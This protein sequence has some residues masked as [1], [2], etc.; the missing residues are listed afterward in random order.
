MIMTMKKVLASLFALF[1][2]SG[3][4]SHAVPAYPGTIQ[5]RQPDG[6]VISIRIHGDEFY[7]YTTCNGQVVARDKDGFYRPAQMPV[8]KSSGIRAARRSARGLSSA[9]QKNSLSIGD[10]RFIVMLIEFSDLPFTVPNAQ[11]AFN[12]MLNQKGYSDNGGTGSVY[13]YYYE[14]SSKKFNPT[15]DVIGPVTLTKGYAEYG[16]NDENDDDKAP[17]EALIEACRIASSQGLCDFSN[18]DNDHD[19]IVDNIFFFYAGHNEA[20]GGGEDTIWPHAWSVGGTKLNGV[21][22]GSYACTSEYKGSTGN[23]M[24]GIGTFCH[25]FGHVLGLPDFYD[26]DYEKNGSANDVYSFSLMCSGSYNNAGRTPP[27][28]SSMERKML[29]WGELVEWNTAGPKTLR[30]VYEN[31]GYFTPTSVDGEFFLYEVRDG[32]GWDSQI[33]ARSGQLPPTG[34][35]V[36]HVDQSGNLVSGKTA[37]SLWGTNSINNYAVHPCYY[38]EVPNNGYYD[39]NDLVYPGT[40]N[41]VRF[42]GVDWAGLPTGYA[43]SDIAYAD[44]QVTLNLSLPT[45]KVLA[46]TVRDSKGNPLKGVQVEVASNSSSGVQSLS[47][48]RVI[49]QR[50]LLRVSG[51]SA[52]TDKDGFY[53]VSIPFDAGVDFTVNFVLDMYCTVTKQV[54]IPR[55]TA[56]LDAVMYDYSELIPSNLQKCSEPSGKALGFNEGNPPYSA[57]IA[58]KFTAAELEGHV[59]SQISKINFLIFGDSAKQVDAF[60]DFG[61]ERVLT[62]KVE[63]PKFKSINSVDVSDAGLTIPENTDIYIGCAVQ[64]I[65]A[66]YW[67]AVDD[68]TGVEGGGMIRSGYCTTGGSNW[69]DSG[70]NFIINASVSARQAN[71]SNMGIKVIANPGK[72]SY[73]V[74]SNF[75]LCFEDAAAGT[76]PQSVTWYYDGVPVSESSV[77]LG[78]AGRHVIKAVIVYDDGSSEET[79]QE[80][81]VK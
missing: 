54:T 58:V 26:V 7:H 29:D 43:L 51:Y 27:Y 81:E 80:I 50:D 60:V 70:Y 12:R 45:S 16:G 66:Q 46:G 61:T 32:S 25:E 68:F 63:D 1:L 56:R 23:N 21:Y 55:S 35:L 6:S 8:R 17:R 75:V 52:V 49:S 33:I 19:G 73:A 42:E 13:D 62:R 40:T 67:M 59:G 74:G 76:K 48:R 15:Y 47:G 28:L 37:A 5:Y 64:D 14:N 20:E 72:G 31:V 2:M 79:V 38:L 44:S 24:A 78:T 18:Y 9:P 22:L 71:F 11:N 53:E 34:M 4:L 41:S 36:Y 30:P 39:F 57:T 10:K 69:F 77:I 65:D 3:I